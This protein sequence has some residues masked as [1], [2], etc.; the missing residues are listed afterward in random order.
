MPEREAV[1]L[2]LCY[3][4]AHFVGMNYFPVFMVI[5]WFSFCSTRSDRFLNS[6]VSTAADESS[7]NIFGMLVG[8]DDDGDDD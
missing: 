3:T 7:S 2:P 6:F 1:T 5:C 4:D 8:S